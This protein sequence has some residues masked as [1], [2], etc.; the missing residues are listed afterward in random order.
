MK[1]VALLTAL[2]LAALAQTPTTIPV[3]PSSQQFYAF[4][5]VSPAVPPIGSQFQL[6]FPSQSGGSQNT[7]PGCGSFESLQYAH[8]NYNIAT[9]SW[10]GPL[11]GPNIA[12]NPTKFYESKTPT[13]QW[14]GFVA[15]M[16]LDGALDTNSSPSTQNFIQATYFS[17]DSCYEYGPE[18]GLYRLFQT[19]G[20]LSE[21]T[22]AVFYYGVN[23]NCYNVGLLGSCRAKDTGSSLIY[24]VVTIPLT[25]P[26]ANSQG[27]HNFLY[28]M[29]VTSP[30]NWH[31]FIKDPYTQAELV[32]T[33][34]A[35]NPSGFFGATAAQMYT[36]GLTG[37]LTSTHQRTSPLGALTE[38]MTNPFKMTIF[39]LAQIVL[40]TAP[41]TFAAGM[42]PANGWC[43]QGNQGI[44]AP[45]AAGA[46]STQRQMQRSY[47]NCT[48]KIFDAGTSN[49]STIFSNNN[50]PPTALGNPFQATSNGFWQFYAANG[51]YTVQISGGGLA[52]PVT[53]G[54]VELFDYSTWVPTNFFVSGTLGVYG[55]GSNNYT[56]GF[57]APTLSASTTW[58]LPA[59]DSA[60]CL[61]SN[62]A[63]LLSF[64]NCT[65]PAPTTPGGPTAA[66]QFNGGG[67]F[68]GS[69]NF[70]WDN[71]AQ[72]LS[73][74][75]RGGTPGLSVATGYITTT[76]G[77][78][79]A[80][81]SWQGFNTS[82]DGALLRGVHIAANVANTKGG[83]IN[84]APLPYGTQPV[85]L[86]GLSSFGVHSG[87]LWV[88][89]LNTAVPD[90]TQ[91]INTNLYINAAGG[92][93][94]C[95]YNS[96]VCTP[97]QFN[98][99]QSPAGGMEALSFSAVNY[100]QVGNSNGPPPLTSG[101]TLNK[102]ATYFDTGSSFLRYWNG[103]TWVDVG[104]GG[105][106]GS[107]GGS[108]YS[109]QI[110]GG[111]GS[112]S[113]DTYFTYTPSSGIVSL[114][115]PAG[116][117]GLTLSNTA[118]NTLSI[119]SGGVTAKWLIAS[120]SAFW[121][122]E[123]APALSAAGQTRMYMDSGTHTLKA[124]INGAAYV[125]VP[126]AGGSGAN[127]ALSNLASV[128]INTA[129]LFQT[130]TDIGSTT[131][132]ARNLFIAGTGTYGTNYFKFTGVPT[133]AR[134]ITVPDRSADMATSSGVLTNGN[135]A[136]FDGSGNVVD[137]GGPCTT[138]G[139]GGTVSSG[140][141]GQVAYYSATGTTVAGSS[142]MSWNN[143]TKVLAVTTSGLTAGM[144]VTN[145]YMQ[146][147]GGFT[148]GST[149]VA[150][151][152]AASGGLSSKWATVSDSV[153]WQQEA[154]PPLSSAGQSKV[155]MDS[156]SHTLKVSQNG[157][158]FVDLVGGGASGVSSLNSLT[159]ALSIVGTANEVT[160]SPSGSTITLAT[161]QP[162]ATTSNV[163]FGSV[164]TSN[165]VSGVFQ[166]A[167]TS[168]NIA[169]Q[170]TSFT[171][172][173]NGNGDIS[174]SGSVNLTGGSS[175]YKMGSSVIVDTSRNATFNNLTVGGT[176]TGCTPQAL[177]TSSSPTFN[178]ITSNGTVTVASNINTLA[179]SY[180]TA[181]SVVINTAGAFVGGGGVNVGSAGISGGNYNLNGGFIGQTYTVT[182]TG[183]ISGIGGCS[184]GLIIRGGIVVSCF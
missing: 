110:N 8:Y 132:P 60:G 129:L 102:G 5:P 75:G 3:S 1:T 99:I 170:T 144:N 142:G 76:G 26:S 141:A 157:G 37:Y 176:C 167:V 36:T 6:T 46:A 2:S 91:A 123:A 97:S 90:T 148:T 133:A 20:T 17:T 16:T 115:N 13:S 87:M 84:L 77:Y 95:A 107:P 65:P 93:L 156:T 166:S 74:V 135:C 61:S 14:A 32:S 15:H 27:T 45:S 68:S 146:S 121:I 43:M 158:S 137:A 24:G 67:T 57:K 64:T 134:T 147:D 7:I 152:Q 28:G 105:G 149:S 58:T 10:S 79:S 54:D 100:I 89:A 63:G 92:F 160:V 143:T 49:L 104:S 139:G 182:F 114:T 73:I 23:V 175:S 21:Q 25:I 52:A 172:Q 127:T 29:Y 112:F 22:T 4:S 85:P 11:T 150:A 180:E 31:V 56:L 178:N 18:F 96:G 33:D 120:D 103:S 130:A 128:S 162:I 113:G 40:M 42:Q 101:D 39:G 155:Y 164:S 38:S 19:P 145:G 71:T 78:V 118:T 9:S 108:T 34:S 131:K 94:V 81:D 159:G 136:S 117:A 41:A 165:S 183:G 125:D 140:T 83:Y 98:S 106:G 161:P 168:T 35:I 70:S 109:I 181:S 138:G 124:S 184:S 151:I 126:G 72:T 163:T 177:T 88:S 171:F 169:F 119:A 62:G 80:V 116:T 59:A 111:S 122:E 51:R 53:I 154:A 179:G 174:S 50:N 153:F 86:T 66:V 47:P 82:T 48:V 173:V 69:A 44:Y 55:L 12:Y 30:T